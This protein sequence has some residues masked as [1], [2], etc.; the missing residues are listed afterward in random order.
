MALST[1]EIKRYKVGEITANGTTEVTLTIPNLK[2]GALIVVGLNTVGGTPAGQPYVSSF[3]PATTN[4]VGFKAGA[5]DTSVYN[6]Y[7]YN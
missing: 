1:G 3:D 5:G 7:V 4:V 2:L 6:I